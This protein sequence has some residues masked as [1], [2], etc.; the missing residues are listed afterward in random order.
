M[1]ITIM[2]LNLARNDA[3]GNHILSLAAILSKNHHVNLMIH[4]SSTIDQQIRQLYD[5]IPAGP[6]DKSSGIRSS[7]LF[8]KLHLEQLITIKR[9]S[10][11]CPGDILWANYPRFYDGLEMFRNRYNKVFGIFDYHGVTPPELWDEPVIKDILTEGVRKRNYCGYAD[12]SIG[13]SDFIINE[14]RDVCGEQEI[15]KMPYAIDINRFA[16]GDGE[17]IRRKYGIDGGNILLYVG[18]IAGNK[19]IDIII[20]ALKEIRKSI[21]DTKFIC[22]GNTNYPHNV[23]FQKL[24][25][26]AAREHLSD[27][28][29]FT[30]QVSDQELPDY[31]HAAN[32]YVTASLH[33]GFCMPVVEAM[34]SGKPV[35]GSNC[36]AIP[37][38]IGGGGL[39]FMPG[40]PHD[41]AIKVVNLLGDQ[42]AY[43]KMTSVG[44][45]QASNYSPDKFEKAVNTLVEKCR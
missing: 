4:D 43:R 27:A 9:S 8:H 5:V 45:K 44:L 6:V 16:R 39:V 11:T 31:Y 40:D 14:L 32:I 38:T 12:L 15:V 1:E 13:H 3:V 24:K 36:T 20:K 30:G 34:A 22:I 28:V 18:R 41:L 19:R 21:P 42:N 33:E 2:N 10:H 29:I 17:K 35:I 25:D 37:E 7:G 23:E 26:L